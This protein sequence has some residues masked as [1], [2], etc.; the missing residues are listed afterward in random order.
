MHSRRRVPFVEVVGEGQ[1]TEEIEKYVVHLDLEVRTSG[2]T[3]VMGA[4]ERFRG[5]SIDRL[6]GTGL[7][8]GELID[9][10]L[11]LWHWQV[12]KNHKKEAS[13]KIIIMSPDLSRIA[14]AI[15][16]I[17]E[18]ITSKE[19]NVSVRMKQPIYRSDPDANLVSGQRAVRQAREKAEAICR[20][21]GLL[22]GSILRV[23]E[24]E[25][26]KRG[27]G[28]YG[29]YDCG[30]ESRLLHAIFGSISDEKEDPALRAAHRT[31]WTRCRVR[32]EVREE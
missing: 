24:L 3:P 1:F 27:S 19:E 11:D 30:D 6:Y 17:E 10:G 25:P 7:Q 12:R 20:V 21:E 22:L 29:D 26:A 5:R 9:G 15:R 4:L 13:H 18:L 8:E 32:F 16:T 23:E 31:I 14:A 28:S 2:D